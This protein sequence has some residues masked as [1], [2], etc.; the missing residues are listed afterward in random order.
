M[1]NAST[2]QLQAQYEIN[3][4]IYCYYEKS[5]ILEN[6]QVSPPPAPQLWTKTENVI[7]I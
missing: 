1:H 3:E 5:Q 4:F 2:L 7:D 6:D